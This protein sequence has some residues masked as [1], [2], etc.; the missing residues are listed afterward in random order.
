MLA[1]AALLALLGLAFVLVLGALDRG[2]LD[3]MFARMLSARFHRQIRF[4]GLQTRLLSADPGLT[5][6][7][8]TIDN[9]ARLH[10]GH[11]AEVRWLH[12]SVDR[13]ALW[14]GSFRLR[15]IAARGVSL[16]LVRFGPMDNNWTFSS[17]PGSGP[18]FEPLRGVSSLSITDSRID[19]RDYGRQLQ[20]AGV[21]GQD[22]TGVLPFHLAGKG[23][24]AGYPVSAALRSGPLHGSAVGRPWPFTAGI[25]D[26]ATTADA[27]GTSGDAFEV[28]AFD[29]VI[30]VK[31]PNLADLGYLF[32]LIV[33]NSPP[34]RLRAHGWSDGTL[35]AFT[36][37]S[38]VVGHSDVRGWISSDH[39]QARRRIRAAFVSRRLDRGIR[40]REG[41]HERPLAAAR[42]NVRPFPHAGDGF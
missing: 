41:D 2:M 33:P 26:G 14:H 37:L 5:V 21:F 38:G 19:M 24:L 39:S 32:R 30:A 6:Q 1:I 11:L 7:G 31:G 34:Y 29:L 4:D 12:L 23:T 8:V 17:S 40:C 42:Y 36:N 10:G 27:H 28:D 25:V 16:H 9:P 15:T 18:A 20:I 13:G 35:F 3:G 22:A